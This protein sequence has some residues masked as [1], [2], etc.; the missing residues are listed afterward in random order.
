VDDFRFVFD[1]ALEGIFIDR[2]DQ[3]DDLFGR[4]MEDPDFKKVV[5]KMLLKQVYARIR[6]DGPT[7]DPSPA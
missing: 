3:N 1:K 6:G 2:M 4:F 5:S 7:D